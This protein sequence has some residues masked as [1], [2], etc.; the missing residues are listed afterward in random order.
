M[1][2]VRSAPELLSCFCTLLYRNRHTS[3]WLHD[4]GCG[5]YNSSSLIVVQHQCTTSIVLLTEKCALYHQ[6]NRKL[7]CDLERTEQLMKQWIAV[8]ALQQE[9]KPQVET[10]NIGVQF[11]FL[12]PVSGNHSFMSAL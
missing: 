12:V 1:N 8:K 10:K 7:Y 3:Q 2:K 11:N 4:A 5:M 6:M 9:T